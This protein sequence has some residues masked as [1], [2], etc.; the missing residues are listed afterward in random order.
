M[1]KETYDPIPQGEEE[2]ESAIHRALEQERG[3]L[4]SR[5][6][7]VEIKDEL[8]KLQ[9][10]AAIKGDERTRQEGLEDEGRKVAFI[11]AELYSGFL[12]RLVELE[13]ETYQ[14]N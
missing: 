3:V 9:K 13:G 1:E 12:K 6:A 10:E 14:S 2:L 5:Q 4:L 11:K 8:A 7:I